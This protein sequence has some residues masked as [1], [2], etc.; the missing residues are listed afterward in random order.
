MRGTDMSCNGLSRRGPGKS[1][2]TESLSRLD[3]DDSTFVLIA[4]YAT[5]ASA[6]YAILNAGR[7][8]GVK[9]SATKLHGDKLLVIR[10]E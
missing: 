7:R 6:R 4:D 5:E 3:V 10:V 8:L 9:F 1:H 2:V